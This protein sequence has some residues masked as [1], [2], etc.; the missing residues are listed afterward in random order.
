MKDREGSK[1]RV[2]RRERGGGGGEEEGRE[3]RE[4]TEGKMLREKKG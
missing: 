4:G 2:F 1:E 3:T